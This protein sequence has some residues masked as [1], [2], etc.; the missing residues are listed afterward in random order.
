MNIAR[1]VFQDTAQTSADTDAEYRPYDLLDNSIQEA[2]FYHVFEKFSEDR[3]GLVCSPA[4]SIPWERLSLMS[5]L[6]E[7]SISICREG[8]LSNGHLIT[9]A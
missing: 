1:W 3:A 2:L 8:A 7:G 6:G 9:L 4:T 5:V